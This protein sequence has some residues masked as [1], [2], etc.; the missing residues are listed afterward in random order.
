MDPFFVLLLCTEQ[1][2]VR[3]WLARTKSQPYLMLVK[4]MGRCAHT[5]LSMHANF[6]LENYI[7]TEKPFIGAE[8]GNR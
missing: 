3:H 6:R 1:S 2:G 5:L 8:H 4:V 7:F